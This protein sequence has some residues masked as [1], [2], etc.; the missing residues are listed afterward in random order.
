MMDLLFEESKKIG[1]D[2]AEN[3]LEKFQK[4]MD[5]L[6]EY[7]EHTNLTAIT[8]PEDIMIKHFFDSIILN[9]YLC[10]KPNAKIVD[11][12]TGAGFPGVP[13]KI[14]RE[15]MELT[16]IDS[17]NKRVIF[18]NQLIEKLGFSA[19]IFHARAEELCHKK[20]HR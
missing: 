12:S 10:I 14:F 1:L 16:L 6:L 2:L 13:M 15:D 4:Y 11:I 5:F 18:L 20:E 8:E 3:Q 7:N 17:L 9:N 19:D